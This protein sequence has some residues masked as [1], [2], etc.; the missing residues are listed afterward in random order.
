M[1]EALELRSR[2]GPRQTALQGDLAESA[3]LGAGLRSLYFQSLEIVEGPVEPR[4]VGNTGVGRKELSPP[5][6]PQ[7]LES[8]LLQGRVPVIEIYDIPYDGIACEEKVRFDD[9]DREAAQGVSG[10]VEDVEVKA[11]PGDLEPVAHEHR[12]LDE[13]SFL[14][15]GAEG[16]RVEALAVVPVRDDGDAGKES[17]GGEVSAISRA[18]TLV[19]RRCPRRG[20]EGPRGTDTLLM[21]APRNP[22]SFL[23]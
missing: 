1:I 20:G 9:V 13:V 18:V 7:P 15:L 5:A 11:P 17:P 12:R 22:S 10:V 16:F 23:G 4:G 3:T 6:G 14:F 19:Q 2:N 8:P 21:P